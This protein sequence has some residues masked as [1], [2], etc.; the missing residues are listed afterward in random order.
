MGIISEIKETFPDFFPEIRRL[1]L[2]Y[3]TKR[4]VHPWIMLYERPQYRLV[5]FKNGEA[6]Q[7]IEPTLHRVYTP[8]VEYTFIIYKGQYPKIALSAVRFCIADGPRK[9]E[10]TTD[11]VDF[12]PNGACFGVSPTIY[13]GCTIAEIITGYWQMTFNCDYG[14]HTGPIFLRNIARYVYNEPS[15]THFQAFKKWEELSPE[16][17]HKCLTHEK[18]KIS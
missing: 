4:G 3:R 5:E 10:R 8:V 16:E 18:I 1:G 6:N 2:Y 13:P 15:T 7:P 14:L 11:T 12:S 9:S 17:V